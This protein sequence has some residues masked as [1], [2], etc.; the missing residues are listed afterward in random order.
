MPGRTTVLGL[1]IGRA[2]TDTSA[3]AGPT[4]AREVDPAAAADMGMAVRVPAFVIVT[5]ALGLGAH[6][7]AGGGMPSP[8]SALL[9]GV[10]LGIAG[11]LFA[12]REQSLPR[13]AAMVWSVQGGIHF[14][15]MAG[16]QHSG[17]HLAALGGHHL[18]VVTVAPPVGVSQ[19]GQFAAASGAATAQHTSLLMIGLHA[20]AGLFLA[21]WLR[22]GESAAFQAARRILPRLLRH[23]AAPP[24]RP[25]L[26]RALPVWSLPARPHTGVLCLASPRRGPPQHAF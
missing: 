4:I 12:L 18:H 2:E 14:V 9:V 24:V 5:L 25:L 11:R 21:A 16:H 15:L 10:L 8:G 23:R 1:P 22:C 7:T 19:V 13:L 6:I 20:A 26:V 3:V 17:T